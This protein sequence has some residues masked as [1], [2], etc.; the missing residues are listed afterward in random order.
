MII[1]KPIINDDPSMKQIEQLKAQVRALTEELAK[2][3]RYI[4]MISEGKSINNSP[5]HMNHHHSN[6]GTKPV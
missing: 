2:A 1:N 5:N 3:N 4:E 6:S